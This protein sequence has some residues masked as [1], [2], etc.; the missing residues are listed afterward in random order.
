MSPLRR[1]A[2]RARNK[3][4]SHPTD[5][6]RAIYCSSRNRYF[7]AI[8]TEK[9]SSWR[10]YLS[11]LTVDT[12][13]QA[14]RY[15][16]G[17]RPS[18]LIAILINRE[19][20]SCVTNKDKADALV[21]ATCMATAE[22]DISDIPDRPFPRKVD[23]TAKYFDDPSHYFSKST[24]LESLNDSYPMKVPGLDCI[25]SWAWV[26]AWEVVHQHILDLFQ[27]VTHQGFI[28]IR[29][30]IARTTMLAKPGKGDYTQPGA[31]RPIALL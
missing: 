23:D 29:W 7:H 3:A 24:V 4:K 10:R 11:T 27:A 19:G 9:T 2:A 1:D 31:Y 25:Q 22:C 20:V 18:P 14:K 21:R 26:L 8:E 6:N 15:A 28:P 13:F 16:S 30:K 12:L 17:P 5:E